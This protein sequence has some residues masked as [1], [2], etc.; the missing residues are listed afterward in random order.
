MSINPARILKL[1]KGSLSVGADADITI[2]DP[3]AE[4]TVNRKTFMSKSTNSPF[5]GWSLQGRAAYTIVSGEK[6]FPF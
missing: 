2:I 4:S 3:D 1:E 6:V 5:H